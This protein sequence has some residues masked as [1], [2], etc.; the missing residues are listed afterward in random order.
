MVEMNELARI[1]AKQVYAELQQEIARLVDAFPEVVEDYLQRTNG[2]AAKRRKG[3]RK[4]ARMTKSKPAT[5]TTPAASGTDALV[6]V[7]L[8]TL[9]M[10]SPLRVPDVM[11]MARTAGFVFGR[12]PSTQLSKALTKMTKMKLVKRS[13]HARGT[14]YTLLSKSAA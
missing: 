1:G 14:R 2:R 4:K 13:G 7:L 9:P 8:A 3:A 6:G 10:K 12:Q 11:G 5:E